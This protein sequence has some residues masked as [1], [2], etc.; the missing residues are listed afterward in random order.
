MLGYA[1]I[2]TLAFVF[3]IGAVIG[4]FLNVV[5]YRLPKGLDFVKGSSFCPACGHRLA[6]LDLVP[7]L[8]YL[9]LGRRCRYCRTP[10]SPRY[11]L[12]ELLCAALCVLC[13]CAYL[14]PLAFLQPL[15]MDGLFGLMLAGEGCSAAN[16]LSAALLFF[17]ICILACVA[18]IDLDTQE[19]PN[20]LSACLAVAG[21]AAM[22]LPANIDPLA[23]LI[24]SLCVSLPMGVFAWLV[25][26]AFGFGDVK[27][28]AAAG[29]VLG[30]Q[31]TLVAAFIAILIGGVQGVILLLS[32]KK[33]RRDHFA[34]GPALCAGIAASLFAGER[35]LAAYLGLF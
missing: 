3:A 30:W 14:Q 23:R 28:I 17:V 4:S 29:L 12:V 25:P 15:S 34:F 5:I 1:Q 7:V 24:G 8:S 9:L 27:L 10:I 20:A 35:I 16:A 18:F 32:G 26:G 22:L 21:I 11:M 19:I 6:P 13:Y 2:I 33:G 31:Q